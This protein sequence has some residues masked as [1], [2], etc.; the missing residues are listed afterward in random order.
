MEPAGM[1][2]TGMA[3][4]AE[5]GR[6]AYTVV[7]RVRRDDRRFALKRP[8]TPA[9]DDEPVLTSFRREAALLAC[10]DHPGVVRAY[11]AGRYDGSPALVTELIGGRSLAAELVNGALP[12]DRV[13]V[14]ARELAEALA[15]AHRTG[16]VHRDI[17]PQNIMVPAGRPAVLIDFGLAALGQNRIAP[18]A[19]VGTFAYGAP[20]QSGMLKRPVDGRS[21][22]Y[23]LGAVLYEC[24]TG[25]PPYLADDVGELLRLHAVAP[26]PDPRD[27]RP[28]LDPA[29]A[30][31]VTRLL[32]KD[33]DD[34]YPSAT[35]LL[36]ALS[37]IDGAADQAGVPVAVA[38]AEWPLCG[39]AAERRA[40]L[41]RWE[42]VRN[43]RGGFAVVR[44]PAGGGRSRLAAEVAAAA[45]GSALVLRTRAVKDEELPLAAVRAAVEGHLTRV[46]E[47]PDERRAEAHE[48][49]RRAA[50]TAGPALVANLSPALTAI[51]G[52]RPGPPADGR[53]DRLFSALAV[54]LTELARQYGG[55]VLEVDDAQWLDA[56]S[57]RVLD[58]LAA[59]LPGAPLLV[60]LTW[61]DDAG[62]P[63][64]PAEVEV[65]AGPLDLAGTAALVASRLPGATVPPELVAHVAARTGGLPLA[66]VEYLRQLVDTGLLAPL[67][68]RWLLDE[69]GLDSLNRT[70]DVGDLIVSRLD[71]LPPDACDLLVAAAVVG[72]HF[73]LDLVTAACALPDERIVAALDVAVA[74]RLVEPRG[75]GRYGF[76]HPNIRDALLARVPATALRRLHATVAAALDALPAQARDAGH[77]YALARHHAQAGADADPSARYASALAAGQQ[78]LADQVPGEAVAFL[79]QARALA[80]A[81]GH[82]AGAELL[83]PLAIA[84]LRAG[85][86]ADTL[87]T[88]EEALAGEREPRRRAELYR[89]MVELHHT[90][91]ADDRATDA[92]RQGLAELGHGLPRNKAV[93]I[94][95]TLALGLVGMLAARF[96]IGFGAVRGRRREEL[97][98]AAALLGSG[99]YAAAVGLRLK[100]V[101]IFALR[102]LY[103]VNRL[104][105]CPPYVQVYGL[106]GY[107]AALLKRRRVAERAFA[108][109]ARAAE[110]LND[111]AMVAF[112][113]WMRSIALVQ[114]GLDDGVGWDKATAQHTRWLEPAQFITGQAAAGLRFVLRGHTRE[115]RTAYEQGLRHLPDPAQAAGTSF[116]M[117]GVM[118]PAQQGRHAEAAAAYAALRAA[119]PDGS[120]TPVQRANIITAA[121]SAAVEQGEFGA[122]FDELVAEFEGL[123][124]RR[125]ELMPHVKWFYIYR[126]HGRLAQLRMAPEG[127]RA[128]RL[129]VA[130][131]AVKETSRVTTTPLLK[132]AH[133]IARAALEQQRGRTEKAIELID[134]VDRVARPLDA[135]LV[136]FEVARIRARAFRQLGLTAEAERQARNAYVLAVDH[137]W[138]HRRRQVRVEFGVDDAPSAAR[139]THAAGASSGTNR[140]LEALQQVS[141]AAASIL[142]P[143]RL[144]G[145][146]LDETLGILGAERALMF[147][148]D[149]AGEPVPFAGRDAAGNDVDAASG[150]GSTL[151]RRVLE[152]GEALVVTGTDEGAALGSRSVVAHGLRSI[153]VAPVQLKGVVRG[154]VYLDSRVARGVF[155]E[156]D[157]SVLTAITHH[158]AVSLETARAAQLDAEVLTSRR[159]QELAETL[160]ASMV[161][162]SA[163]LDPTELLN[164]LFATLY[165][166]A[167]ARAGCLLRGHGPRLTA[168]AVAGAVA[169]GAEIDLSGDAALAA[170]WSAS[171]PT[172]VSGDEL[173]PALRAAVGQHPAALVVPL[174]AREGPVG[175][176]VLAGAGFDDSGRAICAGLA[177]QGMS[178]YDNAVLFSRVRELAT[179]DELTGVPN[180]RHFYA[181]AGTLVAAARRNG[182]ALGA[183]MLDVDSFKKI[184]DTY[185]H[186]VGDDVIRE[187][188][189]RV[190]TTV[191]SCDVLGRYGGEEF[192]AVLPDLDDDV[193]LAERVRAAVAASP[194]PTRGGPVPVTVSV[195][196]ARLTPVDDD[197]DQLLA[198]A[199]LALY[200]AKQA[201]RNRV[202]E[203]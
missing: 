147:V 5:I 69:R 196:L 11:A 199:D 119:F 200:R 64:F 16:L 32:A 198:R 192:A 96:R 39:R 183:I 8:R 80:A 27:L 67:W 99:A 151:V 188:A 132:V 41:T 195:G 63:E 101:A 76:I 165:D 9:V 133:Q 79:E 75:D 111:P 104:G 95:T 102:A 118:V 162:L 180:R 93:L 173:P 156:D 45:D 36:A 155:T 88:L 123:G 131:H 181:L 71:G 143:R 94:V 12:R 129:A 172:V 189:H 170:F 44:G 18:D 98:A 61:L 103:P 81:G 3:V 48:R 50:D 182:R 203:A 141:A 201:G 83:H 82:P 10:V 55:G 149:E 100:E 159:Q 138:E 191:R 13:A 92:V 87:S 174:V 160:R 157:V 179:T 28:D 51:L 66:S 97:A 43:G 166:Q 187:V 144:A 150:Y 168:M 19:A 142:D 117:L 140:R 176:V 154:V 40:L 128:A 134:R 169:S 106:L 62:A 57:H 49:L 146:A 108:R 175:L 42:E 202:E 22:L 105:P 121:A 14:L 77:V 126:A 6:S 116:A 135:P 153:M 7:H 90:T 34:R 185:G 65:S 177:S 167:G 20:E 56:A 190:A 21:D 152:T 47:L 136:S 89:T 148:V 184:N 120:G 72:S 85:R 74:R 91:W 4:E 84:Y 15:A 52:D 139:F 193:D 30:A 114:G 46:R 17:K 113:D 38:G 130:E 171:T 54:F 115:A 70:Q 26:V 29:F 25:R 110:A 163:I 60:V 58:V 53:D 73:R 158:V 164:K 24:L 2:L 31:V 124:L 68:G 194:V 197:L 78:A 112:A 161:E 122:P 33:P 23:S 37:G 107:L 127:E 35:A 145:V 125:S 1:E 109:A 137:G 186:A 178:A 59:D 86:F